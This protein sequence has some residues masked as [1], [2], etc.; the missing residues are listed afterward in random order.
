VVSEEFVEGEIVTPEV[1]DSVDLDVATSSFADYMSS[2]GVASEE[3]EVNH[4]EAVTPEI[5]AEKEQEWTNSVSQQEEESVAPVRK[6]RKPFG[7][8][9][10]GRFK[11]FFENDEAVN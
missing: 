3:E 6:T 5:Q 2:M 11:G 8:S 1:E 10:V 4:E 7:E 9:I